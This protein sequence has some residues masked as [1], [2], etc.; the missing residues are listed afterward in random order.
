MTRLSAQLASG[1]VQPLPGAVHD[2]S[3]VA[4][5]L[6]QMSQARHVG[7]VVVSATATAVPHLQMHPEGAVLV[8]GGTGTLGT[9][10]VS[11]L[12]Q[13]RVKSV[14]IL[15]RSGR[16]SA[17]LAQL[18]GD[19]G[20]ASQ[21]AAVSILACDAACAADGAV[22]EQQL[23]AAQEPLLGVMHAGGVLAD[24]TL[25]KQ[26]MSGVRKVST[27]FR[28]A[29]RSRSHEPIVSSELSFVSL[30]TNAY[31]GSQNRCCN[32]C[33]PVFCL[34][35]DHSALLHHAGVCT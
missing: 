14:I 26:S 3:A 16:A 24:A 21:Q 33:F 5:A 25:N 17:G 35:F 13:Q 30:R 7:K 15:S 20:S 22:L 12:A 6:R 23:L 31:S 29:R 4:A 8:V 27:A 34:Q 2:I 10:M 11:W 19:P 28:I 18:L 32:H 9:L 1:A